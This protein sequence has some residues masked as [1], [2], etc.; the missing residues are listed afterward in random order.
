MW[1]AWHINNIHIPSH[2]YRSKISTIGHLKTTKIPQ[3]GLLEDF[4]GG[5]SNKKNLNIQGYARNENQE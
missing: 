4:M 1:C 3:H 2:I 5:L